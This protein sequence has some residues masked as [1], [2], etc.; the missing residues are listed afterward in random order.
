MG[1]GRI[2]A[3]ADSRKSD[4]KLCNTDDLFWLVFH[5]MPNLSYGE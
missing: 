2:E 1:D 5:E 3:D 4:N